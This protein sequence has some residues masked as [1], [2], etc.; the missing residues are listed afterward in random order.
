MSLSKKAQ[1]NYCCLEL[2]QKEKKKKKP[3]QII[4][5]FNLHEISLYNLAKLDKF[6][7][8]STSSAVRAAY[9]NFFM[10][11]HSQSI[12]HFRVP[13]PFPNTCELV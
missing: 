8:I 5:F 13:G 10:H 1:N 4:I 3:C 7:D 2:L 6:S 12:L 11:S 9:R